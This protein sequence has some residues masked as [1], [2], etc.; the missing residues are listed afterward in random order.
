M[1]SNLTKQTERLS[2][3]EYEKLASKLEKTIVEYSDHLIHDHIK[4]TKFTLKNGFD[5][6]FRDRKKKRE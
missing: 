6:I 1:D 4:E 3:D 2:E 5:V